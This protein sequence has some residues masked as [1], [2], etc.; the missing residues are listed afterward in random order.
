MRVKKV[1][2][3]R[4]KVFKNEDIRAARIMLLDEE[5]SSLG[6]FRRD[7]ALKK[8]DELWL[9]MIQMK[10]DPKENLAVAK[11]MDYGQYQY[12]KQKEEKRKKQSQKRKWLKELKF[13][14]MISEN[15]LR[16]KI[17]KA[18]ELLTEWYTVRLFFRLRWRENVH[19]DK[20]FDK[21]YIIEEEL[22][23]AWRSNGV[24]E[25]RGWFAIVLF[26]TAKK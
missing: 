19:K 7:Q 17:K 2:N 16:L 14:Y 15:D 13:S 11:L 21:M 23:D 20:A 6:T 25:E 4:F 18:R 26:P 12:E 1:T 9:D 24:K 3:K 10:Y 22:G 5:G 8:K